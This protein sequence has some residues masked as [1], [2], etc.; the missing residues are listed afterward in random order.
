MQ[1]ITNARGVVIGGLWSGLLAGV[2]MALFLA[3]CFGLAGKGFFTPF[4]LLGAVFFPSSGAP[5]SSTT[6]IAGIIL[7]LFNSIVLGIVFAAFTRYSTGLTAFIVG[8]LSLVAVWGIAT[9]VALPLFDPPLWRGVSSTMMP[10]WFLSH[11]VFGA[12]LAV[13]PVFV[14]SW[15]EFPADGKVEHRNSPTGHRRAA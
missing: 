5:N 2:S 13:T 3:L 6:A 14:A 15:S 9:F 10:A 4:Q 7:H 1:S 11:L 12:F 8:M